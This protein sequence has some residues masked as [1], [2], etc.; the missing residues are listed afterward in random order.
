MGSAYLQGPT[1]DQF[2]NVQYPKAPGPSVIKAHWIGPVALGLLQTGGAKAVCTVRDPRD[3]VVSDVQFQRRDISHS[4][5]RVSDNLRSLNLYDGQSHTL[6]VKYEDMMAHPLRQVTRIVGHLGVDAAPDVLRQIDAATGLQGSRD[7]IE[8][9][10]Q[11]PADQVIW[12]DHHRVDPS[13]HLHENHIHDAR[14]GKWR[15][16]LPAGRAE[17]LTE[18]FHPWLV[19]LGYDVEEMAG[20][21]E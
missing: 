9:L 14:I 20:A 13:S 6:I 12:F 7:T 17:R 19:K 11:K 10:K 8:K 18:L 1:L 5:Q 16:R 2:L 3:C 21:A 4:I 15:D